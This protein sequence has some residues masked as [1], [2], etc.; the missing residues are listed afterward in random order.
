MTRGTSGT[1]PPRPAGWATALQAVRP[2]ER[3]VMATVPPSGVACSASSRSVSSAPGMQRRSPRG[4]RRWRSPS[5][6][7]K[8]RREG[9][10][11]AGGAPGRV[12]ALARRNFNDQSFHAAMRARGTASA[13]VHRQFD[14]QSFDS[15]HARHYIVFCGCRGQ[16]PGCPPCACAAAA[17]GS[18]D[19]VR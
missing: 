7:A 3:L 8:T 5:R 13:L 14:G 4:P 1:P 11:A 18:R 19:R 6:E 16:P 10:A 9:L 2:G 12:P 17:R 15:F